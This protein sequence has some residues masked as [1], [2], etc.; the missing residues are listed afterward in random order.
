MVEHQ[1]KVI[2]N[3]VAQ[4]ERMN[5]LPQFFGPLLTNT[6]ESYVYD[7]MRFLCKTYSGGYWEFYRLSNGGCYMAPLMESKM[8]VSVNTNFFEGEMSAD[9]AGIVACLFAYSHLAFSYADMS[10][11]YHNLR[12]YALDHDEASLIFQA[13]D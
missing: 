8:H 2:A 5:F 13:T 6:V 9:A 11:R 4:A 12:E 1:E 10:E 3:T 7:F